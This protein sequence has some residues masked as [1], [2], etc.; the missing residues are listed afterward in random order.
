MSD[1]VS[2]ASGGEANVE[3]VMHA[4]GWLDGRVVDTR[5]TGVAG[6]R[7]QIAA[8]RGTFERSTKTATDGTFAFAAVPESIVVSVFQDDDATEPAARDTVAIPERET[9]SI[10]LTLPDARP[11]LAATVRDDRGYPIEGAQL[12]A[13]SLDPAIPLRTT[14]FTDARGEAQIKGAKGGRSPGRGQRAGARTEGRRRGARRRSAGA[15]PRPRRD[16]DG[17]GSL[18]ARRQARRGRGGSLHEPRRAPRADVRRRNLRDEGSRARR[19]NAPRAR[20]RVRAGG[21]RCD[22][23]RH[24]RRA[25]VR[26]PARR[27]RRRGDG[28]RGR[29]RRARR[30]RA[31]CTRR[32]RPRADVP[33]GRRDAARCCGRPTRMGDSSSSIFRKGS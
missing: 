32:A 5:G 20:E 11:P 14:T 18:V 7:V 29:R 19:S 26:D 8:R 17:R 24:R 3:I 13:R 6:A 25:S 23:S 16:G 10:T 30:S 15:R 1:A 4:G 21:A 28:R 9:R 22:D 2:L 27:A 31:G 12:T 33:R